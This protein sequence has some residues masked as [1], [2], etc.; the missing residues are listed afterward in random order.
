MTIVPNFVDRIPSKLEEGIIYISVSVNTAI[1]LCPCGCKTEIVTPIDPSEWNFTYDG[2]TIS[3]SPS[4]GVWGAKCK[5]HYW[6]KRNKIEWSRTYSNS[7]IE[8][9][10]IQERRENSEYYEEMKGRR[11]VK[12][13]N[14]F[15]RLLKFVGL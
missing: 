1:H 8:E 13:P 10:R 4:V 5:S 3:F 14:W 9:V 6:I 12:N 15:R 7:E 11:Q 2:E